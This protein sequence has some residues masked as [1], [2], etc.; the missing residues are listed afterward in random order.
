[1]P[2]I[3]WVPS[4][5]WVTSHAWLRYIFSVAVCSCLPDF[6][7]CSYIR[8]WWDDHKVHTLRNQLRSIK[9]TSDRVQSWCLK[10]RSY[11]NK[12]EDQPCCRCTTNRCLMLYTL[13]WVQ[14]VR[15]RH[16]QNTLDNKFQINRQSIGSFSN[17]RPTVACDRYRL[18]LSEACRRH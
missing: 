6:C 5:R 17:S 18:A 10:N 2:C 9:K 15:P 11:N 3:R 7:S 14:N 16:T 13:L 12:H 4:L 1:M 8:L